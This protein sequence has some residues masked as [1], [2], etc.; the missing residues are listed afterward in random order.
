VTGTRLVKNWTTGP[1]C[2][3]TTP[4]TSEAPAPDVVDPKTA[5][6]ADVPNGAGGFARYPGTFSPT[7]SFSIPNVPAGPYLLVFVDPSGAV[8]TYQTSADV[9]DLGYDLL[10]RTNP[11][12]A[13][14]SP[15]PV[16]FSLSNLDPWIANDQVQLTSGDADLWDAPISGADIGADQLTGSKIEDWAKSAE[17]TALNLL[18]ATDVLWVHQLHTATATDAALAAHAYQYA[19]SATS[20]SAVLTDGAAST[21]PAALAPLTRTAVID[22]TWS[23]NAFETLLPTMAPAASVT[24][25]QHLL[26]VEATPYPLQNPAPVPSGAPELFRLTEPNPTPNFSIGSINYGEFLDVLWSELR[27]VR[28]DATV[29]YTAGTA[30]PLQAVATVQR[31]EP[32]S[33]SPASPIVPGVSPVQAPAIN[34]VSLFTAQTSVGTTPTLSWSAPATGAPTSYRV[35]IYRLYVSGTA[36]AASPVATWAVTSTSVAVPAGVLA[37]GQTYFAALTAFVQSPDTF[38]TAPNR[39]SNVW[40]QATA[41]TATFAP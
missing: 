15:T 23:T 28:Y 39:T 19:S 1:G 13:T 40:N 3:A 32:M 11:T 24:G 17:G 22:V 27:D 14:I 20:T 6:E 21:I 35:T 34:G 33:P 7:G 12:A 26:R 37:A 4:C 31:R 29:S 16:T 25:T 2:T 36:S 10:G 5:I 8:H 41:L 9:V 30:T 18:V 38:S